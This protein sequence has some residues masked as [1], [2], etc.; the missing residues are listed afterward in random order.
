MCPHCGACFC[1]APRPFIDNFWTNAPQ[2]LWVRRRTR[3][4]ATLADA[5]TDFDP[6]RPIVLFA[7]DD[8]VG[9]KIAQQVIRSLG[10][11]VVVANDGEQLLQRARELRPELVITDALMP[12][13]DGR[14]VAK[15][16][17]EEMPSTRV[18]VITSIYKDARYKREA[19]RDF[20][21]D[22]YLTKPIA[23]GRLREVVQRFIDGAA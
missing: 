19:Y 11:N 10:C 22:D 20:E 15:I 14:E 18:V 23:P 4:V 6:E 9:R 13:R 7:D 8:P 3:A 5:A 1:S 16:I 17:K 21:V 12:K 2:S